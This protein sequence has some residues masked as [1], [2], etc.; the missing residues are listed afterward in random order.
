MSVAITAAW[1]L[2]VLAAWPRL[3]WDDMEERHK[4]LTGFLSAV[5]M[6]TILVF[7]PVMVA[8]ILLAVAL[9]DEGPRRVRKWWSASWA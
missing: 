5:L 4:P 9:T 2:F 6:P 3:T 8:A 1:V 7:G